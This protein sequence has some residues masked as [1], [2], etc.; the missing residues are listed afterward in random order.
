MLYCALNNSFFYPGGAIF[1]IKVMNQEFHQIQ[2]R[3]TDSPL[4]RQDFRNMRPTHPAHLP[5]ATG[6][7][8]GGRGMSAAL[9][10][11]P[12]GKWRGPCAHRSPKSLAND[13]SYEQQVTGLSLFSVT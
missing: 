8:R 6:G 11:A 5:R 3:L 7:R 2:V 13:G 1:S 9:A 10:L 12:A 4:F